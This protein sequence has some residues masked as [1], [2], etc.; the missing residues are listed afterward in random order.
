MRISVLAAAV[1]LLTGLNGAV[2]AGDKPPKK[3]GHSVHRAAAAR[4]D[5]AARSSIPRPDA[6]VERDANKLPFGSAIWWDQMQREGRLGG[7][8]P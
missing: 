8:M 3:Q 1:L 2:R 5:S 4:A 7:E 6:Y